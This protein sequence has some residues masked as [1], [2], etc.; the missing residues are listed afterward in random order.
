MSA[1]LNNIAVLIDADNASANSI[2]Q[3]L[4]EIG[5]LGHIS[6]KKI[7]GDW[8]N[9]HIQ[10]WQEALLKYAIDPMQ[11]FAYVKGKNATDIGMVIEAMDLLYSGAYDGFCLISSDS[12]FTSLALRIRKNHIK[13]F[14]FGKRHTVGAFTQACDR[15]FYVEDLLPVPSHSTI[16]TPSLNQLANKAASDTVT[17]WTTKQLQ[18]QTHLINTLNNII[19][20]DPNA[21]NGWSN[22]SHLAGQ[23]SK[24]HDH[25][26]LSKYGYE[27]F[28]TF[29]TALR[30]YDIRRQNNGFWAKI[31]SQNPPTSNRRVV[32]NKPVI[33]QTLANV[34]ST[35]FAATPIVIKIIA[36]ST[37]DAVLFRVDAN[38]KVRG[39][40]DMIFYGQTHS[41]DGT[42]KLDQQLDDSESLSEFSCDLSKQPAAIEQLTFTLSSELLDSLS[43]YLGQISVELNITDTQSNIVLFSGEFD[44]QN[45]TSKS[46]LLFTLTRAGNQ[47]QFAPKHQSIDGNL[48]YLCEKYGVEL[49]DD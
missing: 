26:K 22:L 16:A 5:K 6:C 40:E 33:K 27:K 39:D 15:F 14:G 23:L 10:S 36:A 20:D 21:H 43:L 29:I 46:L 4:Q 7:Y 3:V 28:S 1:K 34:D 45:K 42:I 13:V 48:R 9:A 19:K 38:K 44:L 12:D 31:K 47:W 49:S 41:E 2:G 32:A 17:P 25:I 11:H 24:N 37:I 30:L 8:G 18:S 35:L